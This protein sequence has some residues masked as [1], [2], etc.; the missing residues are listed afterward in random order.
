MLVRHVAL[1]RQDVEWPDTERVS[2][3]LRGGDHVVDHEPHLEKGVVTFGPGLLVEAVCDG[4]H[5]LVLCQASSGWQAAGLWSPP[6][7]ADQH[8]LHRGRNKMT[9]LVMHHAT[10][11]TAIAHDRQRLLRVEVPAIEA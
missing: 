8:L 1:W 6:R 10:H 7:E 9:G 4:R 5:V 2:P 11:Q 3:A